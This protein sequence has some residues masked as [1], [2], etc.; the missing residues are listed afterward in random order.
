MESLPS[1]LDS[2]EKLHYEISAESRLVR[3][4]LKEEQNMQGILSKYRP[5]AQLE[6]FQKVMDLAQHQTDPD[7][8]ERLER[9]A[10]SCLE[11]VLHARIVA[12]DDQ[13]ETFL[14][15]ATVEVNG[16]KIPY[17]ELSLRIQKEK[18][19]NQREKLGSAIEKIHGQGNPYLI[20][21]L[22]REI[23]F[24]KESA[25][26][27]DY[28]S[29]CQQKKKIAYSQLSENL[30]NSQKRT[31]T[32]YRDSMQR[33]LNEEIQ[34]P[35]GS[36]SRWHTS[37]LLHM[38]QFDEWFPKKGFLKRIGST[39]MA[40]GIDLDRY[41]NIHLDL[42]ERPRKNPRACCYGSKI[43]Q[44][45]HLIMKPV[46]GHC[47]YETFLHEAGHALHHANTDPNLPYEYRHLSRSHALSETYAFL[48]QNIT[49]NT[50]WLTRIM[51]IDRTTAKKIR[52]YSLLTDLYMFRRYVAK[53]TAELKF[54]QQQNLNSAKFYAETL[55]ELTEFIYDPISYLFDMDSEFYSVDYLRAWIAEAQLERFL[56]ERYDLVWWENR[57]VKELLMS[58]WFSG[59]KLEPEGLMQEL[60][61]KPFDLSPLE[62]RFQGL[63]SSLDPNTN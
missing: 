48:L 26:L 56:I 12:L 15:R 17:Q 24:L 2:L 59:E 57:K 53:F 60:G 50:E 63:G 6:V 39:F 44:E 23:L 37:Y 7:Q 27:A 16:E 31:Q 13:F 21:I 38:T 40:L 30:W 49:M 14:A 25:G 8:K 51:E 46:G 36:I 47:D 62:T 20:Q 4:G 34:K 22:E 33:W 32:L 61:L 41:S 52:Y 29:Y 10:F 5:L 19:F 28:I 3:V 45:I 43:P 11:V 54:F 1:I 42:E 35:L 55:T 18:D 9:L 58:F